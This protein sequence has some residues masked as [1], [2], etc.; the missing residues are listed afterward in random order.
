MTQGTNSAEPAL[1][2]LRFRREREATWRELET[3][4]ER[5]ER[6]GPGALS[7]EEALRLAQIYRATVSALSVARAISLDLNTRLYLEALCARAFL[8]VHGTRDSLGR[9]LER[10]LRADLPRTVRG[11]RLHVLVAA[12]VM[13]LGAVIAYW[14]TAADSGWYEAF[15]PAYLAGERTPA[16]S[17]ET[18]LETLRDTGEAAELLAFSTRLF[19]HN[20][21]V[22]I[23][24]FALG[25]ALGIPT[26]LLLFHNGLILGAF[27]AL[28]AE[29]GLGLEAVAWLSIHGTTELLAIA[30]AGGAGLVLGD[31]VAFPKARDRM[32]ELASA[33]RRA[34][35]LIVGAVCLLMIAGVLEGVGRQTVQETEARLAIGLGALGLWL[36]YLAVAGRRP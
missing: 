3:L 7:A 34:A 24:A 23:L 27:V 10:F 15:V 31:A 22:A 29:R 28:F 25:F 26:L 9:L 18:L 19:V 6:R 13:S 35:R 36:S 30:L 14:L 11:A 17:D 33:G 5:V 8:F 4:V 21:G 2:S 16:A 20:A 32:S 1:R 12:L